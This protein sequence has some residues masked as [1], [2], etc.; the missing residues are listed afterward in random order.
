MC[1]LWCVFKIGQYFVARRAY[2]VLRGG[3]DG[4]G[5]VEC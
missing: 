4:G 3:D 1:N 2:R 5:R